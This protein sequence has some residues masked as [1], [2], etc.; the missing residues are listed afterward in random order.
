[1]FCIVFLSL[2]V[3]IDVGVKK[4]YT[5]YVFEILIQICNHLNPKRVVFFQ[6]VNMEVVVMRQ[7]Q[8]VKDI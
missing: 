8:K 1:M 7:I 2:L 4:S 5:V 3:D 6:A